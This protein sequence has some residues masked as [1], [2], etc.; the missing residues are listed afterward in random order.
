MKV[1]LFN[2]CIHRIKYMSKIQN[3]YK[4]IQGHFYDCQKALVHTY[5]I[6]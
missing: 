2:E 5:T 1:C 3:A 4:C 6:N